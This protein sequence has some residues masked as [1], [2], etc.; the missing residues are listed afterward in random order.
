MQYKMQNFDHE[1]LDV[2]QA[3]IKF[4]I[5]TESVVNQSPKGRAYLIDQLQ[6]AGSS[7]FVRR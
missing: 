6:R 1:K 5:M 3:A 2:H 4:V 7:V